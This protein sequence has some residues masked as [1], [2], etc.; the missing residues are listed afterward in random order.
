MSRPELAAV[1]PPTASAAREAGHKPQSPLK[2]IRAKCLDCSC[3]Q[4]SE[5]R[6]CEAVKCP[7]WPFRAGRHP[8][9]GLREKTPS[10]PGDFEQGDAIG[11]RSTDEGEA[12]S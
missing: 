2:A 6:R 7:L 8:W 9:H 5:V 1:Y 12:A 11:E 3:Y 4:P 10:D